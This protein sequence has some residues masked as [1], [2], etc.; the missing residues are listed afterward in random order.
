MSEIFSKISEK[1]I[2]RAIVGGFARQF[3][4]WWKATSSSSELALQG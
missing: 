1:D 3:E 2:T 4:K